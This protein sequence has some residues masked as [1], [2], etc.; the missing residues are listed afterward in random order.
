MGLSWHPLPQCGHPDWRPPR[1]DVAI[2]AAAGSCQII[3]KMTQAVNVGA[4]MARLAGQ[5]GAAI[6]AGEVF[7]GLGPEA[8]MRAGT[9]AP[10]RHEGAL[11]MLE[12]ASTLA[13]QSGPLSLTGRCWQLPAH[14]WSAAGGVARLAGSPPPWAQAL[15]AERGVVGAE[16][17][18]RYLRP[19]L[20][21]LC[22]PATMMDMAQAVARLQRAI[23]GGER[24]AIYGDYDV[25]GVCSV[26]VMIETLRALGGV[27]DFH[28]PERRSEGYGLNRAAVERLATTCQ[29][30]VSVDCGVTAHAEVQVARDLGCDVIVVDHHQAPAVLPEACAVIDPQRDDCAY[31]FKGM[32]AAGVAFMLAVSLRRAQR[33]AGAFAS[34]PEPDLRPLLDVVALATV[35]D[36]VPMREGN[37]ILTAAGMA[38][39]ARQPRLGIRALAAVSG[40][41]L[42][43][44][45][46]ADLGFRLG[47]RINA[48]GRMSDAR[49]GVELLLSDDPAVAHELATACDT[50]NRERQE[51]E[52]ATVAAAALQVTQAGWQHQA[53]LLVHDPTWHPG[54]IGLVASRLAARFGLPTVVVGEGG[55][56]SARTA[57]G[58][59]IFS[60]LQEVSAHLTRFGGHK[61]AAGCQMDV[62]RLPLLRRA[63]LAAVEARLG[64]PPYSSTL[65]PDVLL[66]AAG[67]SMATL[68]EVDSL[69]PFGQTNPEP[70]FV[71]LGLEVAD[72]RQVGD[73]HLKLQLAGGSTA[74]GFGLSSVMA[75]IGRHIDALFHLQRN[76]FRGQVSLQLRLID[77]RPASAAEV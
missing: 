53:A 72:K 41:D 51:I 26:V 18:A 16:A 39:M 43:R 68:A 6:R 64:P 55:R 42:A 21:N 48:R 45:Q 49:L 14:A 35:A 11:T 30:I 23:A 22:D 31:P 19:V 57:M 62:A 24:V 54:V 32:C 56:G 29:L 44:V 77:V 61:A 59:D 52:R 47:P 37:R 63:W 73:S 2:C 9:M 67:L 4:V 3:A 10:W 1:W 70:L 8:E 17:Q 27:V 34:R 40:V 25:D 50:A 12:P 75:G 13:A 7:L 46:V 74:I 71:A 15:L 69:Q 28:I 58:M 5:H 60:S 36:M 65:R 38:R 76:V 33:Q 20:A 66:P